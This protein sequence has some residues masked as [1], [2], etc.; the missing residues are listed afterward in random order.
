MEESG[1][2]WK[3]R[4]RLAVFGLMGGLRLLRSVLDWGS[5][6]WGSQDG[7][8][9]LDGLGTGWASDGVPTLE[10]GK[11]MMGGMSIYQLRDPSL[12]SG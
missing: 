7:A 12:R 5:E 1:K 9:E 10:L 8:W 6:R 11:Q 2:T 4:Q 3:T